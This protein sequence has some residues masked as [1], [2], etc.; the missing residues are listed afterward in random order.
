MNH[1]NTHYTPISFLETEQLGD[2]SNPRAGK[3]PAV[4]IV[5]CLPHGA[6]RDV[7]HKIKA[8]LKE[9]ASV[10]LVALSEDVVEDADG[11]KVILLQTGTKLSKLRQFSHHVESEYVCIC[12][13]DVTIESNAVAKVFRSILDAPRDVSSV[14]AYGVIGCRENADLLSRV[15]AID[16]WLSHRVIRPMLWR[17]NIGITIPGQFL[18]LSTSVLRSISPTVDS[19]LD[20][21]YLGWIVRSR[22]GTVLRVNEVIGFEEPRS[23]WSTLLTQRIRWM[24]GLF[25][26]VGHLARQPKAIA[27]LAIHYVAYHGLPILF[28]FTITCL[29]V[30]SLA[31]ALIVFATIVACLAILSRQTIAAAATYVMLFPLLH[32]LATL[33]WWV[34]LSRR[35]LT[36]R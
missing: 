2:I 18:V 22:G 8:S 29:A 17:L 15:I 13:P 28:L 21:L 10:E 14:V 33:L 4:T 30:F 36:Q 6:S 3:T 24:R 5:T 1:T 34:P 7:L 27:F 26:L 19:Y 9:V 16:K 12:D 20:D 25:T 23:S 31:G 32:C 11:W 35:R